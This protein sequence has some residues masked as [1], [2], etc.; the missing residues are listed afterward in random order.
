VKILDVYIQ[1]GKNALNRPFSYLYAGKDPVD[2]GYRVLVDFNGQHIM[3]FVSK[4]SETDKTPEELEAINGFRFAFIE[5]VIDKE[6]LL[7]PEL[8]ELADEVAEHYLS[9]KIAVL[10]AMLPPSLRPSYSALNAPKIAYEDWVEVVDPDETGLSDKQIELMRLVKD[11]GSILKKDFG[12]PSN[13]AKLV[14][15]NKLKIVKKEKERLHIPDYQKE[16]PH[17]LT[18]DQERAYE[19]IKNNPKETILLE[20]VTGSGK[21]EVYLR[22]SEDYLAAGKT[23]LMLVPEISLTPIMVEYF[24]RR[25]HGDVAILHS[26]LTPAEKYDE[27]RRIAQGKAHVVVGARSAIFAPLTNIGLIILDEEHVESYKQDTMPFYHAREVAIMRAKHFGAKVVLGSA[28]PSLESKARAVRGVYGYASLPKRINEK[29]LPTTTIV[30]LTKR[31][32]MYQGSHV[33]STLLISKIKEKLERKEQV[34]LLMNR[35]GYASYVSCSNC[36]HI[37]TCPN[38]H[39]NLTYHKQ[40]NMLKCHHC[41]YVMQYPETCPECGSTKIMRVGFGTERLVKELQLLFP[42]ASIG[43]LDSD[44]GKV[45]NNIAKTLQEFRDRKFD[46]LVGTQM[47]AKGHDFPA[48]TL[49]GV[50]LA[51]IGLS[52]PTYRAS[53]RTFELIT[54]AVGRAGRA[55]K[56]G[57]AIIQ[58]YNPLNYAITLGAK[59]DYEGFYE[60][61]MQ[62]RKISQ[63]PPYTYLV[64]LTFSGKV[65]EKVVGSS[66]D[67]KMDL[68]RH[69]FPGVQTLGPI[70]PYYNFI[71]NY[72][73]RSLLVKYKTPEEIIPYL[74]TLLSTLSGKGGVDIVCDVDPIDY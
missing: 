50:V 42:E 12:S 22:L 71:D 63:Y 2:V 35:R 38:C 14:A 13:L 62:V 29:A 33:F 3:G 39:G 53:E 73:F 66:H 16:Q 57:E 34:V 72:Y 24:S 54:Q 8:M 37:F 4:V 58:T 20:G 68:D 30:D 56:A 21:T 5:R 1:H 10:Q 60:R 11:N 17:D 41:D 28:T 52:L 7:N 70:S 18:I 74:K 46:I 32:L 49:V 6:P 25:F 48:V 45:R 51:D 59:Q 47:I 9:P 31:N 43:R 27:Y 23:I 36:G 61:E 40:D 19:T 67:V 65:E 55:D 44:I 26:E 15:A 69:G 64:A